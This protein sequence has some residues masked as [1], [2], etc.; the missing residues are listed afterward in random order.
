MPHLTFHPFPLSMTSFS[1]LFHRDDGIRADLCA[2]GAGDALGD[3][4]HVGGVIPLAVDD[5]LIDGD[6]VLRAHGGAQLTSLAPVR[7][8]GYLGCHVCKT[9]PF[10]WCRRLSAPTAFSCLW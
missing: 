4:R 8:E 2:A 3:V 9:P 5:G 7:V 1:E 6:D 10:P